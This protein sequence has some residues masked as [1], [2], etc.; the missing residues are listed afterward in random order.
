MDNKDLAKHLESSK[1]QMKDRDKG[2]SPDA[3]IIEFFDLVNDKLN[4]NLAVLEVIVLAATVRSM[5]DWDF[6]L[7]KPGTPV[8]M[9]VMEETMDMRSLSAAM[10]YEGHYDLFVSPKSYIYKRRLEHPFDSILVPAQVLQ[11]KRR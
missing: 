6:R 2:V 1:N 5:Q 9:G 3:F 11:H 8:E 4:V 10:A 7:P